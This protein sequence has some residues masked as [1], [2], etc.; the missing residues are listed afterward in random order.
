MVSLQACLLLLVVLLA[1]FCFVPAR[2]LVWKPCG[3]YGIPRP[4]GEDE[5]YVWSELS[6][7]F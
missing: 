7:K 1:L 2:A 5:E 4:S 3:S 6:V